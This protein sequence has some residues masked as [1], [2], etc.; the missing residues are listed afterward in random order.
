MSV[1]A[2]TI[3][4]ATGCTPALAALY[5]PHLADACTSYD[6]TTPQR[7]AAFL[8]QIGHE[9]GSLKYS[10]ELWGPTPAQQRYEG[11][12]DLGNTQTGDGLRYRGRGLIQITGRFNYGRC[13]DRLRMVL[14]EQMVPDFERVP[15]AL[16]Q[17]QWAAWSAASFWATSGCNDLADAGDFTGIT[18]RINGG[19]NGQADRLDRW[20][21]AK[22]ALGAQDQATAADPV[23]TDPTP[24]PAPIEAPAAPIPAG[25]APDWPPPTPP[26]AKP[27]APLIAALLPSLIEAIPK[28]GALFGN[29]SEVATRNVKAAE[30]AFTVAKT[31][32]GATNEQEVVERI[33]ADPAAAQTVAKAIEANWFEL[34]DAGGG[35]I[36]G[37]RKADA[38]QSGG[39]IRKSAS[40]W[41]S[42]LLLPMAYL[43]VLSLIG[44]IGTASWSDDVR[45]GLAGS[46]ISSII[47]GLVGYYFGQTTTRNRSAA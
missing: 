18:R 9:S 26:K 40:F 37:A 41:I 47:G 2:T 8:A 24:P 34:A 10:A 15:E 36:E 39:D 5:A 17:A 33:K 3:Q 1:I 35:G 21:R 44:L 23:P 12:A 28:L 46:I 6:I 25:E 11:R 31:A 43:F 45:A 7:L 16:E 29:G 13:R 42:L 20:E 14:G 22:A 30:I 19:L 38:A 32:L 27:M 4:A